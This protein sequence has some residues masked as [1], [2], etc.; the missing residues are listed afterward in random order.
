MMALLASFLMVGVLVVTG[1]R[2]AFVD[3]TDSPG[4]S[5]ASG[6]VELVDDDAG[7][8]MFSASGMAP[9]NTVTSCIVVTYQG[10]LTP[11]DVKLYGSVA[12]SGLAGYLDLTVEVGSGGGFGSCAGFASSATLYSGTLAGFAASHADWGS[13]LAAWSPATTPSSQTFRFTVTLQDNNAAQGL[14]AS[15]DFTWE[16]QNA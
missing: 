9:N 7:S 12:G 3:T 10:S 6:T 8:V 13:G 5:F 11:A 15:A 1:S 2:A 16:A 4:N 14:D